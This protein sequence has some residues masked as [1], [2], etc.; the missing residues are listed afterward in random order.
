M[1]KI[2]HY[3]MNSIFYV[4]LFS[5]ILMGRLFSSLNLVKCSLF[6]KTQLICISRRMLLTIFHTEVHLFT[7]GNLAII[8]SSD[9]GTVC[10]VLPSNVLWRINLNELKLNEVNQGIEEKYSSSEE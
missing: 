1:P 6:L 8:L 2:L 9:S 5:I 4:A 10:G 3:T 7:A